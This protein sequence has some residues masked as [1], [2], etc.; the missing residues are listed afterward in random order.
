MCAEERLC[1]GWIASVKEGIAASAMDDIK[2]GISQ[3]LQMQA[4]E[5]AAAA[6]PTEV[7]AAP[8]PTMQRSASL[9]ALPESSSGTGLAA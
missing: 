7:A 1:A 9:D 6:P 8:A 3:A 5:L 4:L 2:S